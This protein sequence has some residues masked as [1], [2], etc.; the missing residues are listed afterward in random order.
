[1][2]PVDSKLCLVCLLV[3][4]SGEPAVGSE[5]ESSTGLG[6]DMPNPTSSSVPVNTDASSSGDVTG[7]TA[8]SDTT[9]EDCRDAV[10]G[11]P[12][13]KS[14][15]FE[16]GGQVAWSH[17]DGLS[18]GWFHTYDAFSSADAVPH[19][20]HVLLPRNYD[21]CGAGYPVVYMNDGDASFW[22]GGAANKSWDVPEALAGLYAAGALDP[23]IVVAVEPNDRNYEYSHVPWTDGLDPETCCGVK[24]YADWLADEVK[25]FVDANYRTRSEPAHTVIV[26][27]SR[28][29]LAS[30]FV[31]NYRPDAF[32]RAACMSPSFWLG[33]DPVFG[34]DVTGGPLA[35]SALVLTLEA[36]LA[37]PDVRPRLWIDWGLVFTGG[38]HNEVIEVAAAARG[39]EMA[40]LLASSYGYVEGQELHWR[41]DPE[42]EH[43]EWSWG[44]RFPD[45]MVAL[46]GA[47]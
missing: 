47:P 20:L 24:H 15:S 35:T 7:D 13:D 39:A 43:D 9:S 1:M 10:P 30:F 4:C 26:G 27:S 44:R 33:L 21:A 36:T 22:P 19:K 2:R 34:E 42:G 5:A 12:A 17:D 16:L 28:G 32:G 8:S 25:G 38:F 46:L 23:V 40:T 18:A 41:A 37:N 11:P 3:A 31:A 29:G 6:P 45:V 14:Y